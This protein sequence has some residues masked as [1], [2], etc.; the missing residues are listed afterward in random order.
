MAVEAQRMNDPIIWPTLAWGLACFAVF[1]SRAL[2]IERRLIDRRNR[3]S[4]AQMRR[5]L[6]GS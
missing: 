5:R 3:Q 1:Y 4:R 2:L 6:Y